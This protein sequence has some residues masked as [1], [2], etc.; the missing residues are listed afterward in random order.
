M[1]FFPWLLIDSGRHITLSMIPSHGRCTC[2]VLEKEVN[3]RKPASSVS[4]VSLSVSA[5]GSCICVVYVLNFCME[6][7]SWLLWTVGCMH[8]LDRRRRV[9]VCSCACTHIYI[10]TITIKWN[11]FDILVFIRLEEH[12][13]YIQ[14]NYKLKWLNYTSKFRTLNKTDQYLA[15]SQKFII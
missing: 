3:G 7:L 12:Y 6:F 10:H 15:S 8:I 14:F 5:L 4:R 11:C 9:C 2:V 1:R 13:N